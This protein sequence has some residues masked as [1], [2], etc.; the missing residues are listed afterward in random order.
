MFEPCARGAPA[1]SRLRVAWRALTRAGMCACVAAC[2]TAPPWTP[3]DAREMYVMPDLP[4]VRVHCFLNCSFPHPPACASQLFAQ[5]VRPALEVVAK[6]YR[7]E[8]WLYVHRF[9]VRDAHERQLLEFKHRQLSRYA[10]H[11]EKLLACARTP[12]ADR[13]LASKSAPPPEL[14]WLVA[15]KRA[16]E[17]L[18][19]TLCDDV[20]AVVSVQLPDVQ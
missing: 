17:H 6:I 1:R 18:C 2:E 4:G 16:A 14:E 11:V 13:P 8:E 7:A 3:F 19:D 10:A 5:I 12:I 20:G 15:F 9:F